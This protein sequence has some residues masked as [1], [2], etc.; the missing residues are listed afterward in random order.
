VSVAPCT[1]LN[2]LCATVRLIKRWKMISPLSIEYQHMARDRLGENSQVTSCSPLSQV[3]MF[4]VLTILR[5]WQ[6][7]RV[8]VIAALE[9]VTNKVA[10]T[11]NS[12]SS[13]LSECMM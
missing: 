6:G 5:N 10:I 7:A 2:A 12:L 3:S 11:G 8:L 1:I 4:T 9:G 13:Q